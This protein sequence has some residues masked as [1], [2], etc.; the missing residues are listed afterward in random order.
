[1]SDRV[2][3]KFP[4]NER[5]AVD[6]AILRAADAVEVFVSDGAHAAMNRFNAAED[7]TSEDAPI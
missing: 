5:D 7:K 3:S 2:L 6:R 1:L 4:P